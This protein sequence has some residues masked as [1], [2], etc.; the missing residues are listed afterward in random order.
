VK[1]TCPF[2]EGKN[3]DSKSSCPYLRG[4]SECPFSGKETQSESCPFLN[5]KNKGKKIYKTIKKTST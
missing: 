5:D 3:D 2:L 4:E 1:T